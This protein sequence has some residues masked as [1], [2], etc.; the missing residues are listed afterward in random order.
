MACTA[1]CS[2]IVYT[3]HYTV[4][5]YEYICYDLCLCLAVAQSQEEYGGRSITYYNSHNNKSNF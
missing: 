1:L 3:I 2:V 5:I 4:T